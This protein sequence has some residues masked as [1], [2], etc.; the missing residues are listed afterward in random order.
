MR[1]LHLFWGGEE[2]SGLQG[3]GEQLETNKDI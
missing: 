3:R 1:I 2:R